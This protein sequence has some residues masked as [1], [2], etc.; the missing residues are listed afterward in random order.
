MCNGPHFLVGL[1]F[2]P[3]RF[4]TATDTYQVTSSRYGGQL[5][6]SREYSSVAFF[7]VY[8]AI[9]QGG[10]SAGQLFS[11]GPNIAQAIASIRRILDTRSS[12][13]GVIQ[14]L[15]PSALSPLVSS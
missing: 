12:P 4:T 3:F 7:V 11:F 13:T 10:Q 1:V 9:V 6:A 2:F 5:L 15:S 8:I 14:E